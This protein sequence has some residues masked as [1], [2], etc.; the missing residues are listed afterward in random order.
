ME[1]ESNSLRCFVV[2]QQDIL[3]HRFQFHLHK[4]IAFEESVWIGENRHETSEKWP[5]ITLLSRSAVVRY[6]TQLS[7]I[8][9]LSKSSVVSVFQ[10]RNIVVKKSEKTKNDQL[11]YS[12]IRSLLQVLDI[13]H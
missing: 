2:H 11:D 4:W 13:N 12:V 7:S 8:G 3:L 9:C 5:R 6:C 10:W 1:I